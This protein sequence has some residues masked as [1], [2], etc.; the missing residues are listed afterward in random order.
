MT[1]RRMANAFVSGI[2]A[3]RKRL[4]AWGDFLAAG[5]EQTM[6]RRMTRVRLAL[7]LLAAVLS[8]PVRGAEPSTDYAA[9]YS[10]C[11]AKQRPLIV[12]VGHYRTDVALAIPTAAHVCLP[13]F[14][15]V[16]GADGALVVGVPWRGELL[17]YD[18]NGYGTVEHVQDAIAGKGKWA[19]PQPAR[20]RQQPA[21]SPPVRYQ[22]IRVSGGC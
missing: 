1:D 13:S 18:V 9:A 6:K 3:Y 22:P 14:P 8:G 17:R 19:R 2:M 7:A 10:E 5:K 21:Y 4:H 15:A 11:L 16:T 12:H 20:T